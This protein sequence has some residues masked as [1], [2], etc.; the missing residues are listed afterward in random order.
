MKT[1][2]YFYI[3]VQIS[4]KANNNDS[5][6]N[7]KKNTIIK[8]I[9][10]KLRFLLFNSYVQSTNKIPEVNVLRLYTKTFSIKQ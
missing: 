8:V 1:V 5:N 6:N 2:L 10:Y 3:F 7:N 4:L 9:Y